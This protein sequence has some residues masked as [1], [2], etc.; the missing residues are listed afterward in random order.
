MTLRKLINWAVGL[1]LA[2]AAAGFA[3]ANRQWVTVSLDPIRRDQPFASVDMPLWVLFFCGVFVGIFIGW[4]A[5]W[6]AHGKWRRAAKEARIELVRIHTEHERMKR[7]HQAQAV[8]P[9]RDTAA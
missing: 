2:V 6:F 9:L 7:E 1:P 5:A 3:V 4:A 8:V